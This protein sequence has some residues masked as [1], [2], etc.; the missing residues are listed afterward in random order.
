MNVRDTHPSPASLSFFLGISA[1]CLHGSG[2]A[3]GVPALRNFGT[4]REVG[5]SS[6]VDR[7]AS[8]PHLVANASARL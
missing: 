1:T 6:D 7:D 3:V 2:S 4:V 8:K 5:A